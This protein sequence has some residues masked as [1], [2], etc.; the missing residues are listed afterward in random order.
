MLGIGMSAMRTSSDGRASRLRVRPS[1]GCGP[2]ECVRLSGDFVLRAC[3]S[4]QV[5][6][7]I[8]HERVCECGCGPRALALPS[9][10]CGLRACVR[11][12]DGYVSRTPWCA[13]VISD[14]A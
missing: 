11:P 3:W 5:M 14:S 13:R 7:V 9:G 10:D 2:W 8:F 12:C 6:V 1:G 4:A